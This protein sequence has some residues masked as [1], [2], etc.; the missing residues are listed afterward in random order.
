MSVNLPSLYARQYADTI[1]LLL[2]QQGSR[3][4]P[5][6]T[7]KGDYKGEQASPVDQIGAV[8]MQEVT[9]RFATMGRVD[10]DVDRRWVFPAS[11]DLPQLVDHFDQLKMIT[12]PKGKY[13]QNGLFAA[14][15]RIDRTIIAKMLGTNKTGKDGSTSTVFLT[16]NVVDVAEGASVNTGLTVAKLIKAKELLMGHNVD[17]EN[18]TLFCGITA[19]ENS[20][21]LREAQ[22]VSLDYNEKPVLVE[23]KVTSF[24]GFNFIHSELFGETL[25]SGDH[26]CL[27]WAKSGV[28]LA[29]WEDVRS[30]IS[31]RN[32]L[33][34]LPWQVYF[35]LTLDATRLEEKKVVNIKCDF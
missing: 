20:S 31:Q 18:D 13:V 6:V 35:W 33:Q 24:M 27:A 30:D 14:G 21:L 17:I 28:H 22:V 23:G 26:Q 32:D 3:L 4:R 16:G 10:A 25:S 15:R 2:Q 29:L 9:T 1:M 11:Y 34:G 8:E 7:E 5:C 19:K 12:D